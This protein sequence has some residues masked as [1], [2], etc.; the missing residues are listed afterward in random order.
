M[1]SGAAFRKTGV[2]WKFATEA[3]LEDFVWANLARLFGWTPL[4]RQ[5][6]VKGQFCDI[7]AIGENKQLVVLELKNTQDRYIV[8]QLTRYYD[9]L[10]E[11]K[12]FKEEVDYRQPV[13]LVAIMPVFHRDN[14]IDVKYH[15]LSFHLLQFSV[16]R[17]DN[18]LYF[19]LKEIDNAR[20]LQL[21]RPYREID[22]T[23]FCE[24]IPEPPRLLLD[25][26]G[27]F[28]GSEQEGILKIRKQL[29][30][31]DR[32][33][34][35]ISDLRSIK[36]GRGKTKLCAELGFER[37][38]KK[39]ILFLWLNIPNRR[40]PAT[41]RMQVHTT[42][43]SFFSQFSHVP[44]GFYNNRKHGTFLLMQG[45]QWVCDRLDV[46]VDEALEKWQARI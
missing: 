26:L 8:Q 20:S 23:E 39:V 33:M 9:A 45:D 30:S 37:K 16:I 6:S 43:W 4:K 2:G 40:K 32:G 21:E 41:G 18:N 3:A 29:L 12:P 44:E 24:N 31:F 42:D 7:L 17:E 11:E 22:L 25:W 10:L 38:S 34:Q 14:F 5:Y 46:L 36:Y 19:Q 28:T 13:S 27:S 35:E 15:N 1:L